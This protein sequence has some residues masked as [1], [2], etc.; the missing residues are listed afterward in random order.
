MLTVRLPDDL[1]AR[2]NTLAKTTNM[3][4]NGDGARFLESGLM[5]RIKI[6]GFAPILRWR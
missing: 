4:E 5:G 1:E 3:A 2:L 6:S